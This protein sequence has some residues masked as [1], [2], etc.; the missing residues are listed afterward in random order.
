MATKQTTAATPAAARARIAQAQAATPPPG[1]A[2]DGADLRAA[3]TAPAAAP[4]APP[5][6]DDWQDF[7][8]P[9]EH[10]RQAAYPFVQWLNGSPPLKQVHP[11]LGAG[12]FMLPT[13]QVEPQP[14]LKP[15]DVPHRNGSSTEAYLVPELGFAVLSTR[16]AW[17]KRTAGQAVYLR[18]YQ[19]GARGRLQVLVLVKGVAE[20]EPV[21]LTL[22]GYASKHFLEVLKAFRREVLGAAKAATG[23]AYPDYAFWLRVRAG[24]PT[25]AGNGSATSTITPPA[26]A[27]DAAALK[28]PE[29][30]RDTLAALYVGKDVLA[31]AQAAWEQAQGWAEAWKRGQEAAPDEG[32][33]EY[34]YDEPPPYAG[35]E[36]PF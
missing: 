18:G 6:D 21:M 31:A 8:A 34:P 35:E 23:R 16:F 17:F 22:S 33:P 28:D 19:E 12:G 5:S 36:V 32:E 13:D 14:S 25:E 15:V 2:A 24:S 4:A 11:V 7:V 10:V 27:W 30:R 29:K 20:A 9:E 1:T 3:A 26:P